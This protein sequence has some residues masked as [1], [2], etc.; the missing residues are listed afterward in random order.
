MKLKIFDKSGSNTSDVVLLEQKAVLKTNLKPNLEDQSARYSKTLQGK[1]DIKSY[2]K[3][4]RG[5]SASPFTA[6]KISSY[7]LAQENDS[8]DLNFLKST[9][10]N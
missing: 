10:T 6:N 7:S 4:F 3:Y 1:N 9:P 2:I 8:G 5:L